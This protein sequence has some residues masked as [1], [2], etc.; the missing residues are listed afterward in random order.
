MLRKYAG[1]AGLI[2]FIVLPL[3]ACGAA[4]SSVRS[5]VSSIAASVTA[6]RTGATGQPTTAEPTT[7]PPTTAPPTTAP[8]TTAPPTTA[9]PTT[10]PPTTAPPTTAPPTT[11]APTTAAPTTAAGGGGSTSGAAAAT[12]PAATGSSV[13]PWVWVLV[14]V[15]I[16]VIAGLVIWAL[17]AHRRRSAAAT[18]WRA[19]VIDAYAKGSAL[20]DAMAAAETPG[21]LTGADAGFRWSDLQRRAD[22]Y[23]QLLYAMQQQAPGEIERIQ[24][25]DVIA[26]LQAARSAMDA[27]R[28]TGAYDSALA[29]IARDRIAFFASSVNSLREPNVRPA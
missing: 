14:A 2:V 28:S 13:S 8:P 5:A 26:S 20:H 9:P 19:R 29:G 25:A 18:D 7:A 17:V 22:D 6:T 24:V 27:E 23:S 1:L 16:V 10:A 21:A 12:T 11:A 15:A 3:A 4:G